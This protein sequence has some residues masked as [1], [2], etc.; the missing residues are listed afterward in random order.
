MTEA[1]ISN[2]T[3]CD[4][5]EYIKNVRETVEFIL[6]ERFEDLFKKNAALIL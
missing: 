6:K 2:I 1:D 3:M 4:N 5:S